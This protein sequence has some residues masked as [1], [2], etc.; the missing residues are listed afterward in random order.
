MKEIGYQELEQKLELHRKWLNHEV[1]GKRLILSNVDM[2]NMRLAG[3]DFSLCVAIKADFK[4]ADLS[5]CL[6]R[7]ADIRDS[8]LSYA[9]ICGADFTGT[10]LY[11]VKKVGVDIGIGYGSEIRTIDGIIEQGRQIDEI[12]KDKVVEIND[13]DIADIEKIATDRL[14]SNIEFEEDDESDW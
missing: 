14:I 4:G 6:F 3:K 11:G 2:S 10:N 7:K 5:N 1:G 13:E 12:E 9:N 8:D